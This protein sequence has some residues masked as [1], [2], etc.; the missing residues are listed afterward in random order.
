MR[1]SSYL[2]YL[3]TLLL[4]AESVDAQLLAKPWLASKIQ[5]PNLTFKRGN[6]LIDYL[7]S[8]VA[9]TAEGSL[10]RVDPSD[11]TIAFAFT[12]DSI[13]D[14][15]L[16]SVSGIAI[17]RDNLA[18]YSVIDAAADEA[19]TSSRVLCVDLE[20]GTLVWSISVNGRVI[21]TPQISEDLVYV[22]HN[23]DVG[24]VSVLQVTDGGEPATVGTFSTEDTTLGPASLVSVNNQDVLAVAS[25]LGNGFSA[26]GGLYMLIEQ[27]L[28]GD[29]KEGGGGGK[30]EE[31]GGGPGGKEEE[32]EDNQAAAFRFILASTF[33]RSS[34]TAP[35][36]SENMEL[37]MAEQGA[38][39]TA[40]AAENDLSDVLAVDFGNEDMA[41]LWQRFVDENPNDGD[42]RKSFLLA[43]LCN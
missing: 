34:I 2:H 41:P 14:R 39:L 9:T 16:S 31:G 23:E 38:S 36:L 15:Q 28:E 10:V 6:A 11:Q 43:I 37:V 7:G 24:K 40:W 27:Q 21:G 12:P 8:V 29:A 18:I 13:A 3:C 33:P 1:T 32:N 26:E 22:V 25:N 20:E 19:E 17:L 35:L 42:A 5:L 30:E 4:F